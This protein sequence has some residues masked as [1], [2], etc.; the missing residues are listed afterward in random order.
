[1]GVYL[2]PLLLKYEAVLCL[3]P[4]ESLVLIGPIE[5]PVEDMLGAGGKLACLGLGKPRVF[6][7]VDRLG[8]CWTTKSNQFLIN[9]QQRS[10][11]TTCFT[12]IDSALSTSIAWSTAITA[13]PTLDGRLTGVKTPELLKEEFSGH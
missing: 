9:K 2:I 3:F 5:E 4:L 1:M 11:C 8:G 12:R 13:D 7:A 6:L 10:E